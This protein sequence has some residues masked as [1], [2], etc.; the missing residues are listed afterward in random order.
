M[1][2]F[3]QDAR[4]RSHPLHLAAYGA[5]ESIAKGNWLFECGERN[6]GFDVGQA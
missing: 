3:V 4:G 1:V 2:F 6:V 5:E